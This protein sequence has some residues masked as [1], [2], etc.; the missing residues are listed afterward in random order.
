[1]L[2]MKGHWGGLAPDGGGV[3][4]FAINFSSTFLQLHSSPNQT[5]LDIKS[6]ALFNAQCMN[7]LVHMQYIYIYF[8]ISISMTS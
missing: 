3:C 1:M 8:I 6:S 7:T 4:C 2:E 5:S